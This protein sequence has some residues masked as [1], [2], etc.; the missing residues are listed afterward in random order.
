MSDLKIDQGKAIIAELCNR[1]DQF[2]SVFRCEDQTGHVNKIDNPSLVLDWLDELE[3][4]YLSAWLTLSEDEEEENF[5]DS[6]EISEELKNR[7]IEDLEFWST[8]DLKTR[9]QTLDLMFVMVSLKPAE[10]GSDQQIEVIVWNG[11]EN[12][13]YKVVGLMRVGR[14]LYIDGLTEEEEERLEMEFDE[15][16][17]GD[18]GE[19][20]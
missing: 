19:D 2:F 5:V 20:L 9:L 1:S 18:L 15:I 17:D 13:P 7:P 6:E 8:P 10:S 11:E 14:Y 12:D 16:D 4:D 3:D